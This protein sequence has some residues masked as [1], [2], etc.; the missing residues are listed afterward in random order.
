MPDAYAVATAAPFRVSHVFDKATGYRTVS[1][2][3]VPL[4]GPDRQ[5]VGVLELINHLGDNGKIVPFPNGNTPDPNCESMR[6]IP[7]LSYKSAMTKNC[8][9]MVTLTLTFKCRKLYRP[10]GGMSVSSA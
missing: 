8:P 1:V 2:L 4:N 3:A 10:F 9:A 5:C 6:F 7:L